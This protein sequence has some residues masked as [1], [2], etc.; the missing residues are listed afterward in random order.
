M[1]VMDFKLEINFLTKTGSN[2]YSVLLDE[3]TLIR[4]CSDD[5][6]DASA[7]ERFGCILNIKLSHD[8]KTI[9]GEPFLK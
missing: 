4:K 7:D 8:D 3:N 2:N 9:L 5:A 1:H 6:Q